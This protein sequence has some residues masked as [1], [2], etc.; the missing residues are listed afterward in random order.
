MLTPIAEP[1]E[2]EII[3]PR[4]LL[5]ERLITC[6]CCR[7]CKRQSDFSVDSFGICEECLGSDAPP[8]GVG[9][10]TDFG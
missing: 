10:S 5:N 2:I 8:L 6:D 9:S 1:I 4:R 7:N 3:P